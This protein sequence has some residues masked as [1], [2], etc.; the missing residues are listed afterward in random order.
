MEKEIYVPYS[1]GGDLSIRVLLF[2]KVNLKIYGLNFCCS[3]N[4]VPI[5][6]D[7]Y[8]ERGKVLTGSKTD[9]NLVRSNKFL[10][11]GYEPEEVKKDSFILQSLAVL[12]EEVYGSK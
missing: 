6:T 4:C 11:V 12:I 7:S 3:L 10:I 5:Y 2:E 9:Y 8:M 1:V